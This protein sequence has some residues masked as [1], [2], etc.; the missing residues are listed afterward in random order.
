MNKPNPNYAVMSLSIAAGDSIEISKTASFMVCLEASASFKVQF[1][2]NPKTDFEAG[3]TFTHRDDFNHV[4][5]INDSA[6]ELDVT[7]GFGRGDIRDARLTIGGSIST[8]AQMPD[9]FT[10]GGPISAVNA[11]TTALAVANAKR[12][13]LLLTNSGTGTVYIGGDA[14]AVAGQGLPL[15]AGAFMQLENTAAI[16]ARNDSGVA[17]AVA[18]AESEWAP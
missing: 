1:D 14:A 15:A 2:R 5:I 18:V 3:L 12:R 7:L 17:V 11:A 10:T 9:V 8:R 4:Q 13:E 6:D 16:Y